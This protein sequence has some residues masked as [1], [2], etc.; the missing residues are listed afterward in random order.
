VSIDYS[1][2]KWSKGSPRVVEQ[3]AKRLTLAEQERQARAIVRQRDHGKC[4][5]PGCKDAATHLHHVV[6]RSKSKRLKWAPE[7]LVSLCAGH[8][9]LI[10]AGRITVT[11]QADGE[12]IFTGA[13][14]DL[15]FKL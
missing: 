10:H 6:Y 12:F 13:K 7:N 8:H 15:A 9:G 5:V 4:K 1:V 14:N 2:L 3:R 11:V